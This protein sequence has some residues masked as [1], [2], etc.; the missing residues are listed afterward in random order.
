MAQASDFD[1]TSAVPLSNRSVC[2]IRLGQPELALADAQ[3]ARALDSEWSKPCYREGVA[4]RL[5][6]VFPLDSLTACQSSI[7]FGSM[8]SI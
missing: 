2:W 7:S 1:P 3:A 5:L 4:L 8:L 6:Q